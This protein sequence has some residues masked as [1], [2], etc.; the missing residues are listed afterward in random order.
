MV[1]D[2]ERIG[3]LCVGVRRATDVAAAVGARSDRLDV[4]AVD[5]PEAAT[6]ALA[7]SDPDCL[8][9]VDE[10]GLSLCTDG[11]A[12]P[13]RIAYLDPGD[14][15]V[16]TALEK[17]RT[18]VVSAAGDAATSVLADRIVT[19]VDRER[20]ARESHAARA[21]FEAL[22][23]NTNFAV[24]TI[25]GD[26]VV[27]YASPAVE[28]LLGYD[29]AELVGE[30][31]T[32]V[33]P[34]RFHDAHREAVAEY[35][36]TGERRLDWGW[37]ELPGRHRDGSEVPLGVSFGERTAGDDHLFSAVIRDVS[38]RNERQ[39]RLDRLAS[40]VEGA[41]DGI[42][43][44]DDDGVFQY[45]NDAHADVYGYDSPDDLEGR[46]WQTLYDARETDRFENDIMPTFRE[47]GQW[48][49]E[50]TGQR[51]DGSTFPQ[52]LSLIELDS[53]GL[54]CVV[55]DITDRVERRRELREERQFTQTVI[56]T[57]PDLFYVLDE[58]GA[59][60]RWNDE[61]AAV[62]GYDDDELD[63][64]H[65]L[66][67]V[68]PE[69]HERVGRAMHAV[70]D[71]EETEDVRADLLTKQGDR[72]PHDFSGNAV[73][74]ADGEV[75]GLAGIGRDISDERLREQRLSVLS[76][77]LRHNVRNR[78][79][80]IRGHAKHVRARVDGPDL[81]DELATV[82]RAATD[83]ALTSDRARRAE[84]LLREDHSIRQQIDLAETIRGAVE[85]ADTDHLVV[86]T[87]LPDSAPA[88]A[89][90][91]VGFAVRELLTNVRE[92]VP[93]PTV[94]ITVDA[95]GDTA[96]V[97][98]ADDGPGIPDHERAAIASDHE[99]PLDHS[100]GL[101]LWLVNWIVTASGGRLTFRE[102]GPGATVVLSFPRA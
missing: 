41:L 30:S 11:H 16:D 68:A 64:M 73:T 102:D 78:T 84:E 17:P 27:R 31:L 8:V 37:I 63:G 55:R 57:L 12:P 62:T 29:P 49:G 74:D 99:S 98:V 14:P 56:D 53:G 15:A 22:T 54:V 80:V 77:V 101:G 19:A 6:E 4:T 97:I 83:L 25:D 50:T 81:Q 21:R 18:Q 36:E 88:V 42:A 85:S 26:S 94:R 67:I 3:V 5:T 13:V 33:M 23:N 92:H 90:E 60:R 72:I 44:L 89:A 46:H 40:A 95:D 48:R 24:V 87:D 1:G 10:A 35:L 65:A 32:A 79:N 70:L 58:S 66:E 45:V 20:A 91:A 39:E 96:D 75:V 52:E 47:Q 61:L 51:A 71:D 100:T 86:E 43:I 69:D 93:D 82:E 9:A 59:F 7:S 34:E 2:S 38:E 76:R 28:D